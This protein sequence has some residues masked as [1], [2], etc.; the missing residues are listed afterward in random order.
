MPDKGHQPD[1]NTR[2]GWM[3]HRRLM[4]QLLAAG[5]Y[6]AS[7]AA[8]PTPYFLGSH[9]AQRELLDRFHNPSADANLGAYWYWLGG[10][11]TAEG[12]TADLEAMHAAGIM[13]PMLFS[14]GKSDKNSP[15]SPP[16]NALT[17]Y[18]WELVQHAVREA[19]RLGQT[20]ALNDCDGWAT[21]SGPWITPELSM[22]HLVWSQEIAAGGRTFSATLPLPPHLD[23][24]Y[25]D[26][27][28]LAMPFPKEWSTT[29]YTAGAKITSNLPLEVT[30]T[31]KITDP[32]ND[33]EI[34]DTQESGWIT[35]AFDR[36]FTLRSVTVH[37]PSPWGFAPGVY[38]AANSL[39]VQASDDGIH[40][41]TIGSLEYP[42]NGWQ[43]DLTTLTHAV[44]QTTARW[45]RLVHHK[46]PPQPYEEEYDF[47]QDTRLRF[48]S[49]VLSS[50]PRIHH[51][52]DKNGGQWGISRAT[53]AADVPDSACVKISEIHNLT[54]QMSP[55]GTLSWDAPPGRWRILRIGYSTTGK[56]NSA[57]G[58]AQGLECDRFN[59]AAAK[60]QFDSWFGRALAKVGSEYAGKVLH[61]IHVD[62]WEAGTQNWSPDFDG[63]FK[64]LR[65]YDLMPY[66]PAM[67][68]VPVESADTSERVLFDLRWTVSDLAY[69]KF[70]RT[71]TDL[72]HANGC[73]FSAEPPNPTFFCDGLEYASYA[74]MPMG[75]F[76]LH[77]PRNDK[78]TD[79][80]D[81]VSGGR[82]YG[83]TVIG[84]ESFTEGLMNWR[85]APFT[86]KA[87]GDHNYCEGI[88]R[89]ML[90]VY[91]QQPWLDRAP[92]MTLNGIG[93]FF[94]RTQTWWKP[95]KAWFSYLRRCQALLQVGMPVTDVCVFTGE[96]V[97]AR[98]Y[99]PRNLP[100]AI[101]SGHAYD[102]I[103]RDALLRLA[104]VEDGEI[105]LESGMRYRALVLPNV[106][107][108]T[109]QL[110]VRLRELVM[111][112]ATVVGPAPEHSPSM[113]QGPQADETV[114]SVARELWGDLD[115]TTR[116]SRNAGR[117]RVVW[118]MPLETLFAEAG[119]TPD[120][121]FKR[122]AGAALPPGTV[123][124]THRRGKDWDLY[125]LSNQS[126]ETVRFEA[127]FRVQGKVPELWH[128]DTGAHESLGWWRSESGRTIAPL[129]LEPAGSVFVVFEASDKKTDPVVAVESGDPA[130]I[131]LRQGRWL[132]AFIERPGRWRLRRRSGRIINIH[133]GRALRAQTLPGPW[134]LRFAERLAKPITMTQRELVSWTELTQPELKYFSGTAVY[135]T[136][137]VLGSRELDRL[138]LDLGEV[139]DLAQVRVN[140]RF[141]GTLWKP[142][143][144]ADITRVAR[145]GT[146]T[147]E[148]EVTNTWNNRLIGDDGKTGAERTT[149]VFPMLRKGKSWL[150]HGD[151]MLAPAGLLGPVRIRPVAVRR[152]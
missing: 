66:L 53:T 47:G 45:F 74:D 28:V 64:R 49:I 95:A 57:A 13:R 44:P 48:Y 140:G 121:E 130:A 119:F 32:S 146:N 16:A 92:G 59:A 1:N 131:G 38:R 143:F 2:T 147:L 142:P 84:A 52:R 141:V 93:T 94:S 7:A 18:W 135:H 110:A 117:G 71:I 99:L 37:T 113:E 98:S 88:N 150:P 145:A 8:K 76:W 112:G 12:I 151:A 65:G 68:G 14:I 134:T 122:E 9:R 91:A 63:E 102:S 29:S 10:N 78:P 27:A 83:K 58:G 55:D 97:P 24:Y 17:P 33:K 123:E 20:L 128:P 132:V 72:A 70:F 50:E 116:T 77:T 114:R 144:V 104:R 124:W 22:Q 42:K 90:H 108:M 86:L 125:F 46:I 81:A 73:V 6:A 148:I 3:I 11:V 61:V 69:E 5:G 25:R 126:G 100:I 62:S 136:T 43:T 15:I 96:N 39:E 120:V 111:A 54:K 137:F 80:K 35:Y 75:E 103:N 82:V 85:E 51:W 4:L 133:E 19:G 67:T 87:L 152:L 41:H 129:A 36:P 56:T 101:P 60:L 138:L 79:I 106:R 89:F 109:P 30:D 40:F 23:N 21:A 118:G 107:T 26:I 139:H 105:V 31:R 127:S 115:G 149:Y 34:V